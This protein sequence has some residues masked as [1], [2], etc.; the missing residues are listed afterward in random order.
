[1]RSYTIV[2]GVCL[3]EINSRQK[4][5]IAVMNIYDKLIAKESLPEEKDFRNNFV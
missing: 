3:A 1:M 4:A 2:Y 5:Q